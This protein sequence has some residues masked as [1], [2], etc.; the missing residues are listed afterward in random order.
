[1]TFASLIRKYS[2]SLLCL[3]ALVG[4]MYQSCSK[5]AATDLTEAILTAEN[6][7]TPALK[8]LMTTLGLPSGDSL[9]EIVAV[10]QKAWLRKPG[11]ERW[12]QPEQFQDKK[13]I[14]MPLFVQLNLINEIKPEHSFYDYVLVL[15]GTVERVRTRLAYMKKLHERGI[16]CRRII[17]LTGQ[18]LL[19]P[20]IEGE[21]ELLDRTNTDLPIRDAWQLQG[22]LP[23]T[24]T[25]MIKMVVDQSD[26]APEL[27]KKIM[28]IDTPM[29]VAA[30]G[31]TR[32]PNTGETITYWMGSN[33][34]PGS[35][36]AIS[37]QPYIGYQH[38]VL[39][40][41]LPSDFNIETVG[42]ELEPDYTIANILDSLARWLYQEQ[43]RRDG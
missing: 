39:K 15:G 7:P 4:I 18:R 1:M 26:L 23:T 14:L 34:M 32:R 37:N 40:T 19:D 21:K 11:T 36:V 8:H 3:V 13:Q 16:S 10:T 25:E 17:V 38:S 41:Y 43:M 33:P 22:A 29:Q 20:K 24:E 27:K 28:I 6:K 9:P 35:C 30:D 2:L 12:D 31:S 5:S 42:H